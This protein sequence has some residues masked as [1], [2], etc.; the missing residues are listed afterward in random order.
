MAGDTY[1]VCVG[2]WVLTGLRLDE[3]GDQPP[4]CDSQS[5]WV[6]LLHLPH[7]EQ[8]LTGALTLS[9][10]GQA[11]PA[12]EASVSTGGAGGP[13]G[14]QACAAGHGGSESPTKV[15]CAVW[16]RL[17]GLTLDQR[18]AILTASSLAAVYGQGAVLSVYDQQAL[19]AL[20][21]HVANASAGIST[22]GPPGP[23]SQAV[24]APRMQTGGR[25]ARRHPAGLPPITWEGPDVAGDGVSVLVT[26][27]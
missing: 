21:D 25:L 24:P 26:V 14:P 13:S 20:A 9:G 5:Q 22:L 7:S 15:L 16:V 19:C 10:W 18:A 12:S 2:D 4:G 1:A 11:Q 17:G 8:A 6:S 23:R 27:S 3:S